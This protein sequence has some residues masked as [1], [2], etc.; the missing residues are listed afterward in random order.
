MLIPTHPGVRRGRV[1]SVSGG[2]VLQY[3]IYE[4]VS[5]IKKLA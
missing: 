5:S 2:Q 3:Y 4:W 1:E